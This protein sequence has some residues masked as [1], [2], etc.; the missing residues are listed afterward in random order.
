MYN[1]ACISLQRTWCSY[2]NNLSSHFKGISAI[3]I[4]NNDGFISDADSTSDDINKSDDE[5]D[6]LIPINQLYQLY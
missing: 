1:T 3:P 6:K 4:D 5:Q 2:C